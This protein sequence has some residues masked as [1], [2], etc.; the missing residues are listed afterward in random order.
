[1]TIDDVR[2]MNVDRFCQVVM[3]ALEAR[4]IT[5]VEAVELIKLYY[6]SLFEKN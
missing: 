6:G 1:M 3:V 4:R 5:G 2:N